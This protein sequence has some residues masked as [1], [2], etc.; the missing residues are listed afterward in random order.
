MKIDHERKKLVLFRRGGISEQ[1]LAAVMTGKTDSQSA[2]LFLG[3][4]I[5][6]LKKA[7]VHKEEKTQSLPRAARLMMCWGKK[8]QVST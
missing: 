2:S 7:A 4:E 6:V 3:Y 1:Q 5:E 8:H